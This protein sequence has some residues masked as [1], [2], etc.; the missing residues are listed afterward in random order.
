[1]AWTSVQLTTVVTLRSVS[2]RTGVSDEVDMSVDRVLAIAVILSAALSGAGVGPMPGDGREP[3]AAGAERPAAGQAATSGPRQSEG[4]FDLMSSGDLEKTRALLVQ[5]PRVV[6]ATDAAGRTPLFA[7]VAARGAGGVPAAI[8][9]GKSP[10]TLTYVANMGVLLASG[11]TKVLID[12]LFD[13]PNP[14]YRAPAPDVLEAMTRGTAP[15]DGVDLAM[16]THNHPD[17]FD[18]GVAVRFLEN[19]RSATLVAPSDAVAEMRKAATDWARIEPRVISLD[20]AVGASAARRV[21]SVAFTALRTLHS[22]N[23]ESPMNLMYLLEFTG[24]RLFHDGDSPGNVD[25][26]KHFGLAGSPVDLAV[27]HYWWPLEPNAARFLQEDFKPTHL[28]LTHLPIRLE[29]DAPGKI[30]Q[31]R[32]YYQDI[33]LLLPG[34][35]PRTFPVRGGTR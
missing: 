5:D 8:G 34:M 10:L 20:V 30:D 9:E 1:M 25:D 21:G 14:A 35:P 26:F 4:I 15:F 32:R 29:S 13:K 11:D 33:F 24:W 22:G 12:A 23:N 6:T 19:R 18:A 2:V 16:V 27:V 31:V 28:A 3:R 17:H 7:A